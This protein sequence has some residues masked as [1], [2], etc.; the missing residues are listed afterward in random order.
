MG[1]PNTGCVGYELRANL[2]FNTNNSMATSGNPTGADSGDTYWNGGAGW[3]PI[4][5]ADASPHA[6]TAYTGEFDGQTYTISN[7]FIDRTSGDYA[8]LFAHLNGTNQTI[9]NVS[10]VNLDVTLNV[11]SGSSVHVGGLAGRAGRSVT[12]EDS[13]TTGRVRAGESATDPVTLTATPGYSYVGGLG[14]QSFGPPSLRQLLPGGR[15]VEHQ[16]RFRQ[17]E[18]VTLAA[19]WERCGHPVAASPPPMRPATSPPTSWG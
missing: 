10:L 12:L 19:W 13:Y 14:G 2:D 3:L 9:E 15:D 18:R 5:M 4:G 16:E 8:G 1:C 17:T 6:V 11:T 7:L